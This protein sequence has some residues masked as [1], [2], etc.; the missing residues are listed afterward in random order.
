[1][2]LLNS[3]KSTT[4]RIGYA[5]VQGA[6]NLANS[7]NPMTWTPK[8]AAQKVALNTAE[9]YSKT[10][11]VLAKEGAL[12]GKAAKIVGHITPVISAA[13]YLSDVYTFG[14]GFYKGWQ[15]YGVNHR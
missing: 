9:R 15:A 12:A 5:T 4:M 11:N 1:M 8:N 14:K 10:L 3:M 13:S 7:Y 6:K 2:S